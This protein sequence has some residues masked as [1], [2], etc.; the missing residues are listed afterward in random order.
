MAIEQLLSWVTR[1]LR[2]AAGKL[3]SRTTPAVPQH[4]MMAAHDSVKFTISMEYYNED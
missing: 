3:L 4:S 1:C 2:Q